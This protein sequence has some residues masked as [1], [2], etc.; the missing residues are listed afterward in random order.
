MQDAIS[1]AWA[2]QLIIGFKKNENAAQSC[3][4]RKR[5]A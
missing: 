4:P 1:G 3:C 5:D 2:R